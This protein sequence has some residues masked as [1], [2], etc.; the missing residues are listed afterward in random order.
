MFGLKL[1]E[2]S[3]FWLLYLR[4][5]TSDKFLTGN[6]LRKEE[7][8]IDPC[9]DEFW[10]APRGRWMFHE[11]WIRIG[12]RVAAA[13]TFAIHSVMKRRGSVVRI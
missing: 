4:S 5:W 12:V 13:V 2:I 9:Y 8:F 7:A 1:S 6:E 11:R 3:L 10:K